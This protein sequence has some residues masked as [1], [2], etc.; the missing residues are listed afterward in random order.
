MAEREK[1]IFGDNGSV[2]GGVYFFDPLHLVNQ[3]D[4]CKGWA[5]MFEEYSDSTQAAIWLH[6]LPFQRIANGDYLGLD[7]SAEQDDPPVVYLAHD[8]DSQIIAPSFTSFLQTWADLC[9][10]GPESWMIDL[11]Q[12][13]NGFLD[14]TSPQAALWREM[15]RAR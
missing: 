14:A 2:W 4:I 9:Y 7:I 6:S 5:A 10:F 11:F 12:A 15:L 1:H 3:L 8:G 13:E